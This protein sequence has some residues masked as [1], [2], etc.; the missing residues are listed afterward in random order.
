MRAG[1]V[2]LLS[3]QLRGF[4]IAEYTL[5]VHSKN[6]SE[7]QLDAQAIHITEFYSAAE[8]DITSK[9]SIEP[10]RS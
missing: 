7:I 3:A 6:I 2:S 10:D 1:D 4:T 9:A 5:L 8:Y